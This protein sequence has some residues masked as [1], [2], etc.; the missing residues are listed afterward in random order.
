MEP[1]VSTSILAVVVVFTALV[2]T[3][4]WLAITCITIR[5]RRF[6][7]LHQLEQE[8]TQA[9]IGDLDS[10][11]IQYNATARTAKAA[12][13]AD[14]EIETVAMAPHYN[15]DLRGNLEKKIKAD[16]EEAEKKKNN[17]MSWF[18]GKSG[19]T[20]ATAPPMPKMTEEERIR[21]QLEAVQRVQDEQ[22]EASYARFNSALQSG[23]RTGGTFAGELQH[24]DST[25]E[26]R[27]QFGEFE[28]RKMHGGP[29]H[30]LPIP[31]R[32]PRVCPSPSPSALNS[33][34]NP[35]GR[36]PQYM[37]GMSHSRTS[38]LTLAT[39]TMG[40]DR[41]IE[42]P[43]PFQGD[44]PGRPRTSN[45]LRREA[46]SPR[47]GT[48]GTMSS[49]MS[50]ERRYMESPPPQMGWNRSGEERYNPHNMI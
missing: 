1:T 31:Q 10:D 21:Q 29:E 19:P 45:T 15:I 27:S 38:S 35:N 44:Q 50:G 11:D 17:R 43:R 30:M 36:T 14:G 47:P 28:F 48:S 18:G 20:I 13:Y 3:L 22:L 42:S 8:R 37:S 12:G 24:A 4:A 16:Q 34:N 32:S 9:K 39:T 26:M 5:M 7:I 23:N 46:G 2:T 33:P 41:R 49:M 25:G 40:T 6:D